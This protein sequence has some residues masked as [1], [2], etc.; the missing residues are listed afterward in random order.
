V[1]P[2]MLPTLQ[3]IEAAAERIQGV[4]SKTPLV[5]YPGLSK[6]FGLEVYL[7]LES[8]QPIRVFKIRG[9]FNKISQL[10]TDKVVA[11]SSGNHGLAVSYSA[12]LTGK[13]ATVVIPENAV[14]EKADAIEEYG[15]EIVR[16]G[17]YHFERE[18]K[19]VEISKK[20]GAAFV[21]P[22]NDPDVI[23][24]QGTCGLEIAAQLKDF[25][26]IIVPVGGGGLISGISI[27]VKSLRPSAK[28]F[29]VEPEGATK[30]QMSLQAGRPVRLDSPKSIADGLIPSTV[31]ELTLE[32]CRR[33]VEGM[34]HVSDD[35][36]LSAMR[37]LID[38]AH[39][40][41]EP[42]GSAPLAGLMSHSDS[43][44]LGKKIVLVISG[45]NVSR[46]L[47]SRVISME[48]APRS[49]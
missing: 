48:T 42:S 1:K 37:L 21:H 15:A 44:M 9:A 23:A 5:H 8:F 7:K 20:T 17:K 26:S 19:A 11:A 28:V 47:L 34:L 31:G 49:T 41:P 25:D 24:G 38:D 39:V 6:R 18:A 35:M 10:T 45:G 40:F 36:I 43:T 29:G 33:N 14:E 16:S 27:A 46:E 12:H 32:A 3:D 2:S 30:M 13:K 22:F 4:A